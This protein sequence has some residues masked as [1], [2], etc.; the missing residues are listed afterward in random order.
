[1][2][3]V[4]ERRI[5]VPRPQQED[6]GNVAVEEAPPTGD[7]LE[8]DDAGPGPDDPRR[9]S[10]DG[11]I[12]DDGSLVWAQPPPTN[13]QAVSPT[14]TEAPARRGHTWGQALI[15]VAGIAALVFGVGAVALGGLAGPVT[16]PV[17]RVFTYPHTPLLGLIEIGVGVVLVLAALVPGGRWIAGP[18]GVGLVV[19]GALVVTELD[20]IRTELAAER[21]FGAVPIIVGTITYLGAMVPG[22][23]RPARS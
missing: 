11:T 12:I 5:I 22:K 20:W 9:I 18:V 1:M 17:V 14:R 15:M 16:T 3:A 23:R 7:T 8:H 2:W 21:R 4:R 10:D 19:A 6:Q 13:V